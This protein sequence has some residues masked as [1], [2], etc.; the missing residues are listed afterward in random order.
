MGNH[1]V[2]IAINWP[3]LSQ[4][5]R[6]NFLSHVAEHCQYCLGSLFSQTDYLISEIAIRKKKTAA[7]GNW[8]QMREIV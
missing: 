6:S 1:M 5:Q 2:T 3:A 7:E 4:S 8:L